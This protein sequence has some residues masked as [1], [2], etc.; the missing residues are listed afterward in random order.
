MAR[1]ETHAS[2]MIIDAWRASRDAAGPPTAPARPY[3]MRYFARA[4]RSGLTARVVTPSYFADTRY[5]ACL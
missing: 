4:A 3:F 5:L 2:G 1:P